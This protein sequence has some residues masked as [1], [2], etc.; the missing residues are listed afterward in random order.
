MNTRPGG[1]KNQFRSLFGKTR[2]RDVAE[3]ILI[4]VGEREIDRKVWAWGWDG[5]N[6]PLEY[7]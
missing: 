5:K 4:G 6:N 3:K 2:K 1:V 7:T